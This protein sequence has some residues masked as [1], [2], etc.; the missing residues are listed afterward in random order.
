MT[1]PATEV[2]ERSPKSKRKRRR[3]TAFLVL[4]AI[5]LT[6]CNLT[7][8]HLMHRY[9]GKQERNPETGILHGAEPRTLGPEDSDTAILFVHGFVGSG[10]NFW[11][12]PDR[13]AAKGYRVRVMLHA[14]HGTTPEDFAQ[15]PP[16][17]LLEHTLEEVRALKQDYDKVILVGH[18]MGGALATIA[19]SMEEVDGLVLGAPYFGVTHQ[20]YY[21]LPVETWN[22][23]TSP[24][25]RRVYKGNAFIRVKRPEAK[26]QIMSYRWIPTEGSRTL[27]RIGKQAK[28]PETLSKIDIPV[29]LIHATDDFAASPKAAQDAVAAM[30]SENKT[31]LLLGNSDH[32]IFWD[33]QREEVYEEIVAFLDGLK[34]AQASE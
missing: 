21:I 4:L 13:L 24:V 6:G 7:T 8:R 5:A 29:L 9:D 28:S 10:N 27:M 20:W 25:I 11:E 19:A 17:A 15:T 18:S 23:I 2:L 12:V 22:R 33:Y 31:V 1:E 30:P 26:S 14:G 32:H 34:E 3:I 16:D